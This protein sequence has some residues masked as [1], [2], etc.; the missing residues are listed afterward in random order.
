[1][2]Q[3]LLTMNNTTQEV[4]LAL[5]SRGFIS[6]EG[7]FE[8]SSLISMHT[9]KRARPSDNEPQP[10]GWWGD[11]FPIVPGDQIG[12]HL[13]RLAR[14]NLSVSTLRKAKLFLD[15]AFRWYVDDGIASS[16]EVE[17][18]KQEGDILAARVRIIRPNGHAWEHVW[19]VHVNAI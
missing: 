4:D 18:E 14:E 11:S 5:D 7:G 10:F 12:S 19:K 2:S 1:M 17:T 9:N 8:T 3:V 6:L 15:E 13:W 16:V